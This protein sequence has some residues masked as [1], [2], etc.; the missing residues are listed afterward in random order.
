MKSFIWLFYFTWQTWLFI[1]IG[2]QS[3]LN[4]ETKCRMSS[5]TIDTCSRL[6]FPVDV[7]TR[8]DSLSKFWFGYFGICFK[9]SVT[10]LIKK[11]F[12]TPAPPPRKNLKWLVG[13]SLFFST[14]LQCNKYCIIKLNTCCWSSFSWEYI[15]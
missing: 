13:N 5:N 6:D 9:Y 15:S 1:L 11:L 8:I 2:F 10:A 12:P 14:N 7:V 3:W 4:R